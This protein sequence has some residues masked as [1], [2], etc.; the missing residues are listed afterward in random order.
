MDPIKEAFSRIKQDINFLKQEIFNLKTE[1]QNLQFQQTI[2]TDNPTNTFNQTD[3]QTHLQTIPTQDCTLQGFSRQNINISTGNGG[4]P[5]DRQT[6]RQTDNQTENGS[7]NIRNTLPPV[8]KDPISEFKRANE[9]LSS[10]DNIKKEIRFKF[11]SLTPQEMLVFSTLYSLQEQKISEIT[12]KLLANN[13]T[14]TESSI[15]DYI[16]KITKK[17]VPIEK[18]RQNNKKIVLKVSPDLQN[19]ATL[20]TIIRLREL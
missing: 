5:T 3:N 2:P 20:D 9:I 16:N 11:K 10:L 15:R 14:L 19:V 12:Y 17:G 18:I 1:L 7:H 8:G 4:V 6:I 13:L